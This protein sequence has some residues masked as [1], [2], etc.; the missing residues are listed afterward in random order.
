M[1]FRSKTCKTN[2]NASLVELRLYPGWHIHCHEIQK[3]ADTAVAELERATGE[4]IHPVNVTL[5]ANRA[6]MHF[7]TTIPVIVGL[8]PKLYA[9]GFKACKGN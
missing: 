2:R 4:A 9:A 6:G 5:S 7:A 8:L 1:K 3:A